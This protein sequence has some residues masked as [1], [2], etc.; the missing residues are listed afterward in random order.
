VARLFLCEGLNIVL[1]L[2][3]RDIRVGSRLF[4]RLDDFVQITQLRIEPRQ[5]RTLFLQSALRLCVLRL[6]WPFWSV[7]C[8]QLSQLLRKNRELILMYA[9]HPSR[10][11]WP[12]IEVP[13]AFHRFL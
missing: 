3:D 4:L 11:F 8:E 12:M 1:E 7:V 6:S 13:D 5:R 9:P 10:L 2:L